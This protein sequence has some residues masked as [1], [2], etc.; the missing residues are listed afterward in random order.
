MVII[1]RPKEV[2]VF[3]YSTGQHNPI[4]WG[5]IRDYIS[6]LRMAIA[7]SGML[8]YPNVMYITSKTAYHIATFLFHY[9]PAYIIDFLTFIVGKK[10]KLVYK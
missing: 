2:K 3:T 10:T 1:I 4:K 6:D 9:I 5:Q 7:V 8:W